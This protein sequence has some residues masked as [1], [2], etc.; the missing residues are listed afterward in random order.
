MYD[1]LSKTRSRMMMATTSS[2]QN[3]AASRMSTT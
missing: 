1:I 2:R 3:D